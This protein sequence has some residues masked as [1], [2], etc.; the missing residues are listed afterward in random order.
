MLAASVPIQC[1]A[2]MS[3]SQGLCSS[4]MEFAWKSHI[5]LMF[6][7]PGDFTSFLGEVSTW[8]VR[9]GGGCG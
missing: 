1:L 2:V 8:Q 5:K 7:S 4:L 6:P 9:Q 3:L